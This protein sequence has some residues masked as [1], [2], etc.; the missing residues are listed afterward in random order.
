MAKSNRVPF[1][2]FMDFL[3]Q[4]GLSKVTVVQE[5]KAGP[6]HPAFDFY[7]AIRE[8]LIDF[9]E[10][11]KPKKALASLAMG[12]ADPK[13]APHYLAIV[14]GHKKFLG[15]QTLQWVAPPRA[16]WPAGSIEIAVNP[17][18]GLEIGGNP[19][20]IKLYFKAEKL[21]KKNVPIITRLMELALGPKA[22]GAKLAVLDVRR[23]H[24][25]VHPGTQPGLDALL[26]AEAATFASILAS[27]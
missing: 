10:A 11:G 9:H 25:H 4:S 26:Q 23:G 1:S 3:M 21:P 12:L 15:K 27:P 8:G 2:T 14:K 24:L 17:E 13:K 7:R 5:F 22:A 6:Y 18:L 16:N 19:H 20:L